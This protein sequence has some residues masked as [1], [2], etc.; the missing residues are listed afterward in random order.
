[1]RTVFIGCT[2]HARVHPCTL[3]APYLCAPSPASRSR[4]HEHVLLDGRRQ[5]QHRRGPVGL[6][7]RQ[8]ARFS[9]F[10]PCRAYTALLHWWIVLAF[11]QE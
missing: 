7:G 11:N 3:I 5:A 1:M 9:S 2:L 10:L 4:R 6:C 8:G